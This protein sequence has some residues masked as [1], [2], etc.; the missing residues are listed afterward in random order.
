[1]ADSLW[2]HVEREVR[3]FFQ[4][5]VHAV[6]E[7][8]DGV[9]RLLEAI[10]AAEATPQTLAS[11]T[12]LVTAV[13]APGAEA[14]V[15]NLSALQERIA[16]IVDAAEQLFGVLGALA[17]NLFEL[18]LDSYLRRYA[19]RVYS[20]LALLGVARIEDDGVTVFDWSRLGLMRN[21]K[22]L[23]VD[24][25][26]W[27][28]A[29]FNTSLLF[30]RLRNLLQAFGAEASIAIASEAAKLAADPIGSTE[31]RAA[32]AAPLFQRVVDDD[33]VVAVGLV[34]IPVDGGAA[35]DKG[36]AIFPEIT[37]GFDAGP[38]G[39]EWEVAFDGRGATGY[40]AI[41]RPSATSI[42][43][44]PGA[45]GDASASFSGRITRS[46]GERWALALDENISVGADGIEARVAFQLSSRPAFQASLDVHGFEL[47]LAPSGDGLLA[48]VLPP[49]GLSTR[50][51]FTIEWSNETGLH[52]RGS[53]GFAITL[54]LD[55]GL[56][57]LTLT[58]LVLSAE[59]GS[60]RGALTL[61]AGVGLRLALGPVKA[62]VEGLGVDLA[63][64]LDR[65]GTSPA[66]GGGA[67]LGPFG[68]HVAPRLPTL[69][70]IV[71]EAPP[72]TGGGFL[73]RDPLTSTYAGALQLAFEDIGITAL[74]ILTTKAAD[75]SKLT[76]ILG[77]IAVTFS[78]AIPLGYGFFLN[79]LG[80][81]FGTH[82]RMDLDA[83]EDR[84]WAG[85]LDSILFPSDPV[86]NAPAVIADLQAIFP[87][88]R[89]RFVFGPMAS[90]IWGNP[91]VLRAEI[92]VFVELPSP[93]RI[94]LLGQ[95]SVQL[96]QSENPIVDLNIDVAGL[97]NPAESELKIL[98]TL[99]DSKVAGLSVH[100]DMGLL[101]RW[102]PNDPT[103]AASVGGFHPDFK[104]P[105]GM[106]A[107]RR[108]GISL[109]SGDNPRIELEGYL[110]LTSNTGQFGARA[111]IKATQSGFTAHG[112][113]GFDALIQ[114]SPFGVLASLSGG[115]S[116]SKWGETLLSATLDAHLRGPKPW[117]AWGK[118]SFEVLS[119]DKSVHFDAEFGS[120]QARP[121]LPA[122][123]PTPLLDEA[124]GRARSWQA[125][126]RPDAAARVTYAEDPPALAASA[127]LASPD[128]VLEFRQ[129]VVPLGVTINRFGNA[130][131]PTP[132]TLD[133]ALQ[134]TAGVAFAQSD[135][136]DAFAPAQFF[137]LS[138]SKRLASAGF[139]THKSGFALGAG[140]P[141]LGSSASVP[142]G[143]EEFEI[144]AL[145]QRP[146]RAVGLRK[147][148]ATS[149]GLASDVFAA[150]L[151]AQLPSSARVASR[152]GA[153]AIKLKEPTYVVASSE[154]MQAVAAVL[155]GGS[156]SLRRAEQTLASH[157][158]A[159]PEQADQ[160]V[161][162]RRS[163]VQP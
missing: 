25:Y 95:V 125:T 26:G 31:R 126:A 134:T 96:P 116:I 90:I 133:V 115:V 146:T 64:D 114:F 107:L 63:I 39:P 161:I 51:D 156:T 56:G 163:G 18:L 13:A 10:G 81:L 154:T 48:A 111:E 5:L 20:S 131:T 151:H 53:A 92:G 4:P 3:A 41:I 122:E 138:D 144:G 85:A 109:G 72:V 97:F 28:E 152:R 52:F 147:P 74:G 79:G 80:G 19:P 32:L 103:F 127:L 16:S 1:M 60:D 45:A 47:K 132:L 36:V 23:L 99:R 6:D 162:V 7:G 42:G 70:G 49:E 135:L 159:H 62:A 9:A 139:E 24:V 58:D 44:L 150:R 94:A 124:I 22:K 15:S 136:E 46:A 66:S 68:I 82:R 108:V 84:F 8:D 88:A 30:N 71:V 100:G 123:D 130:K 89:G 145:A 104:P 117:H 137:D 35:A 77:I 98:G 83:L 87:T 54:P 155:P 149:I 129:R 105:Q 73:S 69:I 34:A 86:A 120:K 153:A 113:L 110:A 57:P 78:P 128:G 33:T 67:R 50:S 40:A 101:V 65:P 14:S 102:G 119:C 143:Y 75:G 12:A 59:L 29:G 76:S 112:Y 140:A 93:I 118:V 148:S 27:G 106:P 17:E 61:G 91:A 2:T 43:S 158:A 55:L 21:P 121:E 142:V 38:L 37:A 11:I 157:V 160:L 141:L